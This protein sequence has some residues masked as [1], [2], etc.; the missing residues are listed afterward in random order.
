MKRPHF[1]SSKPLLLISAAV[2]LALSS[3]IPSAHAAYGHPGNRHIFPKQAA[4]FGTTFTW[5]YIFLS[6]TPISNCTSKGL[7]LRGE[8]GEEAEL[9]LRSIGIYT[10]HCALKE[11]NGWRLSY[12]P[13][14]NVSHWSGDATSDYARSTFDIAFIPMLR[15]EPKWAWLPLPID[16][17][18]GVGPSFMEKPNIGDRQK[19]TNFQFSDHF[20]IGVSA[21]DRSWR[22]G[23]AFRHLS[24]LNLGNPNNGANFFGVS[25]EM[26]LK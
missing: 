7:N 22:A 25:V 10:H 9:T 2:L 12:T 24:N 23:F 17:E 18:V 1:L 26:R 20:G 11:W 15:Y 13:M 8:Y 14:F 21:P 16:F 3:A 4:I 6:G 5:A 19:T